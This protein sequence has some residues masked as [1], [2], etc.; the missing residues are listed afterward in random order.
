MAPAAHAAVHAGAQARALALWERAVGLD[1]WDRDDALLGAL[2]GG[3][4]APQALGARNAA[5]LAIRNS[6]FDGQWPLR[7]RCP[8]CGAE[9]EFAADSLALARSLAD[10]G[11]PASPASIPWH[12]DTM[13]LRVPMARD[14]RA[15]SRHPDRCAAAR[16]LL[17]RCIDGLDPARLDDEAL[18]E[19]E[20]QIEALDPAA[21]VSFDLACPDCSHRWSA[22]VDVAEAV[23]SE[24]RLAAERTLTD[25]D[26]LARAY[27]WTEDEVL[28]LSPARRAA[29][30]QLVEAG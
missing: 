12:G 11:T 15:I 29:Y 23:W 16:A 2:L 22:A 3:P 13:K 28:R 4:A 14:L 30:L 7:S 27:G 21:V 10:I 24:L 1:R 8:A 18:D 26:A 6:V 25:V 17:A 19:L 9:L 5:L 20:R